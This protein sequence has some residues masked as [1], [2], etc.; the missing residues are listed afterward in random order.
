MMSSKI[1]LLKSQ[2]ILS[3]LNGHELDVLH[4]VQAA[5]QAHAQGQSSLPY[6]SFLSFPDQARNR[7]I[8]L[9]AYLGGEFQVAGIKWIASFPDNLE[10]GLDRASAVV[11]LNSLVTGRP[12][13]LLE[14]SAISAHRTASSAA[15]AAMRL[16]SD[17][18]INRVGI[19]GCGPLNLEIVKYLRLA[20]PEIEGLVIF[21]L[22]VERARRFQQKCLEAAPRLGVMIAPA[23][24][25]VFS[26]TSLISLATNTIEPHISDLSGCSPGSL[27]LHISLRDISPAALLACDNVVDDV[28][29]ICRAQTSLHLAEQL[30][31]NRD[32]IRCTLGEILLGTAQARKN[33]LSTIFSPFGLGILDIAVGKFVADFALRHHLGMLVESFLPDIDAGAQ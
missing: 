16:K 12:E 8:A 28:D 31:G 33:G 2:E 26:K 24:N 10:R 18:P 5:Y 25:K 23:L 7:I 32:F 17:Q 1:L 29:H 11:I 21:D 27:L 22:H 4:T 6:S 15:L 9:P 20:F 3:I 19:I 30:V 14:G 13:A